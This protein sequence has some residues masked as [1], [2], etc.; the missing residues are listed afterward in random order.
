MGYGD[1]GKEKTGVGWEERDVWNE[2][3]GRIKIQLLLLSRF[4]RV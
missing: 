3:L 1:G 2:L 4:S